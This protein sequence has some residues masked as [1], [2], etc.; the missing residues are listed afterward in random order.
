MEA[1]KNKYGLIFSIIFHK[2]KFNVELKN[3]AKVSIDASRFPT[4]IELLGAVTIAASCSKISENKLELSFDL[5]NKFEISLDNLTYESENGRLLSLLFQ[6]T[7]YGASFVTKDNVDLKLPGKTIRII[8]IEKK[9]IIET[10]SGVKFYLDSISPGIIVEAYIRDMHNIDP[11]EDFNGKVVVDAGA[12]CGDTPLYYA[13]KGAKVFAFEPVKAHYDAM[14]RNIGLN[15][16]LAKRIVPI[17]AAIGKDGILKFYISNKGAI[18]GGASFVYNNQGSDMKIVDVKGYSLESAYAEFKIEHI[19]L[20]KMDCKGCEFFMN[21]QGLQIVD[22][23]KIEYQA[24]DDSHR[25]EDLIKTLEENGFKWL[26]YRHAPHNR[27]NAYAG[28][29]YAKKIRN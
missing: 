28:L 9:K 27:S 23:V 20:L 21:K 26:I 12:E 11:S 22:S 7:L 18:A 25:V 1:V 10:S 14:I 17:N 4:L 15:Q 2:P 5:K 6:G 13:S 24:Y 8:E 29:L 3:G 16:H 19:D